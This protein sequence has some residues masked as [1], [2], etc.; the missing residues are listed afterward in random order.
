[1]IKIKKGPEPAELV[2]YRQ[3]P[4]A[5]Y[6][7][8]H[9]AR[10]GKYKADGSPEDVYAVVLDNL[11]REQGCICAYCMCRIPEKGKNATIEHIQPQ[12]VSPGQALDYRNMLAVCDGNRSSHSNAHKT[13]DARRGDSP[14]SVNP[15]LADTIVDIKY[16]SDGTIYSDKAAVQ[17]DLDVTLNLN[18][19]ERRLPENRKFALDQLLQ[20]IRKKHPTGS[21]KQYCQDKLAEYQTES[22]HSPYVGILIYWLE[23]HAR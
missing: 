6:Q 1:M 2:Q 22:P 3:L 23:K 17:N 8:M 5:T 16:R 15:L 7:D 14:L 21:I 11:I 4:G 10:T 12:S 9:G 19:K 13:C 20:E 18:C